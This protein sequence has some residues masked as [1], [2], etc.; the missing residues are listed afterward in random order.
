MRSASGKESAK[1]EKDDALEES[2]DILIQESFFFLKLFA[3]QIDV[4]THSASTGIV[5]T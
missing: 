4:I 2:I 1:D 3:E 5:L